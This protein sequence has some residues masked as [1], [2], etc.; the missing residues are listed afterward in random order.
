MVGNVGVMLAT[1]L[2]DKATGVAQLPVDVG[3]NV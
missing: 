3:V 2:M 1:T